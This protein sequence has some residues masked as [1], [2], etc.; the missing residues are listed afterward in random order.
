MKGENNIALSEILQRFPTFSEILDYTSKKHPDQNFLITEHETWTY[1]EFNKLVNQCCYYLREQGVLPG[2]ILSAVLRN[3]LDY[4]VLYFACIRS[5]IL[6]NPFPFHVHANEIQAKVESI[7]GKI[8]VCHNDHFEGFTQTNASL[9]NFDDIAG[10]PF[11][12]VINDF[13]I[14][15]FP[16]PQLDDKDHTAILYYSSGT[17]GNPKLIEYTHRS[18]VMSQASMVRAGYVNPSEKHLCVLP[19]GHTA[20]LRHTIKP[21]ICTGSTVYLYESFWKIKNNI[22]DI[23]EQNEINFFNIVPTILVAT[24]NIPYPKFSQ[25][26]VRTMK[27]IACSSS[28]L[29]RKQQLEFQ[30]RFGIPVSN[31]YGCSEIGAAFFDNPLESGWTPGSVGKPFDVFKAAIFN[32]KKEILKQGATGEIGVSGSG[33]L[34]GYLNNPNAFEASMHQGYF[35]TG[36]LGYV[37]DDGSFHYV[38]R[39]KDIIIKGGVNISPSQIDELL[40]THPSVKEVATVGKLDPFMGEVIKSFIILMEN[41]TV[42]KKELLL[43][44]E[45]ELGDFKTPSEIQFVESLPKGPSGKILKRKLRENN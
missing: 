28:F 36:D 26:Q 14:I 8:L 18:M 39:K 11:M 15:D 9:I 34:K 35:M 25:D 16:S 20:A 6:F 22:W 33:V 2:E 21:C 5:R 29:S 30:E 10:K 19:L 43:F 1:S 12:K 32:E 41:S 31:L 24:M 7:N 38:D 44:C 4:L 27:F 3:S 40:Q 23:V 17:T 37:D 42:D 13:E 45:G